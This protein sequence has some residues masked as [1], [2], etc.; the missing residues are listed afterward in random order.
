MRGGGVSCHDLCFGIGVALLAPGSTRLSAISS[1]PLPV[2]S[3][4]SSI[5][6][7]FTLSLPD[8]CIHLSLLL[9]PYSPACLPACQPSP[10]YLTHFSPPVFYL[11]LLHS[12][13][14]HIHS[15]HFPSNKACI[16]HTQVGLCLCLCLGPPHYT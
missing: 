15:L 6:Q 2:S 3:P 1:S 4:A 8:Q 16:T 5:H 9:D 14:I 13:D 12:C 10:L 11:G 7:P